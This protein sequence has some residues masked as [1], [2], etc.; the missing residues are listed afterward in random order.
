MAVKRVYAV[1]CNYK[2]C[3]KE[4]VITRVEIRLQLFPCTNKNVS[5]VVINLTSS[6][7]ELKG[8]QQPHDVSEYL[9]I[10]FFSPFVVGLW[11]EG[12]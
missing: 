1:R 12:T 9:V 11:L 4:I 3:I 8:I 2:P 10:W 5:T 7:V 6:G